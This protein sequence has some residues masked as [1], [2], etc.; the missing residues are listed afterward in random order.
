[1]SKQFQREDC[2]YPYV[3]TPQTPSLPLVQVF[4][5]NPLCSLDDH[6]CTK[7]DDSCFPVYGANYSNSSSPTCLFPAGNGLS[8]VLPSGFR[9]LS[10]SL[11]LPSFS[12]SVA[13]IPWLPSPYLSLPPSPPPILPLFLLLLL[14]FASLNSFSVSADL[15]HAI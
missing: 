12:P 15:N 4:K 14:L 3:N 7:F 1:M 9:S 5:R 2:S 11:L 10:I 13:F 6:P 8:N